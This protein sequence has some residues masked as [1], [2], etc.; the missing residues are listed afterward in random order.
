MKPATDAPLISVTQA[1]NILGRAPATAY[2]WA[3]RGELPGLVTIHG[4]YYVRRAV[5]EAWLVGSSTLA[6]SNGGTH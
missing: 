5:L 6:D 4:R 2:E 1:A 3:R